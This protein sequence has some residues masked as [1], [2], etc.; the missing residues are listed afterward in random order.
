MPGPVWSKLSSEAQSASQGSTTEKEVTGGGGLGGE[1]TAGGGG[2][3]APADWKEQPSRAF[4]S[5]AG[6][7]HGIRTI[8]V[9]RDREGGGWPNGSFWESKR[10]SV[11]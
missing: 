3:T 9:K 7:K 6:G 8:S 4:P 5:E 1:A 2:G 10:N 11:S